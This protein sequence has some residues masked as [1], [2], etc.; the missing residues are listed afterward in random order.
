MIRLLIFSLSILILSCNND[1]EKNSSSGKIDSLQTQMH[2]LQDEKDSLIQLLQQPSSTFEGWFNP[3]YDGSALLKK[4]IKDPEE[5]IV[6]ALKSKPEL[7]PSDA[8]LGG[9]MRFVKIDVLSDKWVIA[10]YEDG[11]VMGKAL[12]SYE[13]LNDGSV[14]FKLMDSI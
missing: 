8:V 11:H 7:I 3:S 4:G 5:H 1:M 10:Q 9:S 2:I 14:R 13:I 12:F 6:E